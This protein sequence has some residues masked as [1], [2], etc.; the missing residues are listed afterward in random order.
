MTIWNSTC[1]PCFST[2]DQIFFCVSW[3]KNSFFCYSLKL[4][5]FC[6]LNRFFTF[7]YSLMDG[8]RHTFLRAKTNFNYNGRWVNCVHILVNYNGRWVNCVH[9]LVNYNGRWSNG[10]HKLVNYN[11]RWV[12]CVHILVNYTG[13]I[14]PDHLSKVI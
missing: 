6:Y 1:N 8:G 14:N 4:N 11:E 2:F 3:I 10:I 13:P 9:I 7:D 5:F 12:N